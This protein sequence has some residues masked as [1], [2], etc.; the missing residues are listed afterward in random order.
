MSTKTVSLR[1]SAYEKLKSLKRKDESF[2]DVVERISENRDLEG[3]EGSYPEIG[4]VKEQIKKE[5]KQLLSLPMEPVVA[6]PDRVAGQHY[7]SGTIKKK[8]S[9]EEHRT[10]PIIGWRCAPLSK[11]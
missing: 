7:Y 2:S 9:P 11:H 4:E 6:I 8:K 1:E 3:L 5:R 10:P